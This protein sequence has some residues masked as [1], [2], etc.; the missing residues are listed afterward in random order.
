MSHWHFYRNIVWIQY[1]GSIDAMLDAFASDQ[2]CYGGYFNWYAQWANVLQVP[3]VLKF[4]DLS[5]EFDYLFVVKYFQAI[6]SNGILLMGGL[7]VNP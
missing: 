2:H 6:P 3:S 7:I 5:T 4:T 1:K